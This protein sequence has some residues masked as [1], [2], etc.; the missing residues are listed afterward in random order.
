MNKFKQKDWNDITLRQFNNIASYLKLQDDYTTLNI[1]AEIYPEVD[2]ETISINDFSTSFKDAMSF[3]NT[4]IPHVKLK[5]TYTL[6][7]TVYKSNFDLTIVSVAQF[8]DYQ[9]YIKNEK[10]NNYENILSIFV[11]PEGHS[12]NDGYDLDKAKQDIKELPMPVIK[13]AAFFF[14]IQFAEFLEIF[15]QYLEKSIKKMDLPQEQINMKKQLLEELQKISLAN[16][17]LSPQS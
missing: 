1:L 10:T 12:Y 5:D 15:Q 8:I 13:T 3:L 7:D 16:L 11:I 6:N 14:T 2:F 9:N 17:V 4:D